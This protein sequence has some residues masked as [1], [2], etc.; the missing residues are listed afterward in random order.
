MPV[1]IS[2]E[3]IFAEDLRQEVGKTSLMGIMEGALLLDPD[4]PLQLNRIV[5]QIGLL[6]N[7]NQ[8]VS[9]NYNPHIEI[10]S[11]NGEVK[12]IQLPWP[13]PFLDKLISPVSGISRIAFN[14]SFSNFAVALSGDI[15][16]K[17]IIE[18]N[19]SIIGTL[20]CRSFPL[21]KSQNKN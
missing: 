12:N 21:D 2:A 6:V 9:N 16:V 13:P 14:M 20:P 11:S 18:G 7:R 10:I 4:L 8:K 1:I 3:A 19:S 17:I 15:V 5:I